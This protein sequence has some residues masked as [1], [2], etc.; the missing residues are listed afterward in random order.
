MTSTGTLLNDWYAAPARDLPWR[1][2]GTTPW[3]VLLS[4]VMSQQTPVARVI[5]R[6][7]RWLELWPRPADLAA[8]P[9]ADVLR[10]WGS[11]GYPRRALRLRECAQ[12][13][14]DALPDTVAGLEALP[15][16]GTYTARAVAAF[17]F[18]RAVPVVDTNVRRVHHRL[19]RGVRLPG[20][21]RATDLVDVADLMPWV[22]E[23]PALTRRGYTNPTHDPA[24]RD[25]ALGMCASLMELGATV[26]VART[27]RCDRCPVLD[28]CRW[29]ALGRPEPTE[30]ERADA[31]RRVQTFEGTDR[32]ARGRIMALLRSRETADAAALAGVWGDAGQRDRA[33]RSLMDDGL[34]TRTGDVW[35]L[36][37]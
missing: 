33:V 15:G 3:A 14:G 9:T 1:R 8:A 16:I 4:E 23:D 27:P 7:E 19:V 10:E 31:R 28:R 24:R 18:G 34:V 32:Q 29:T 20:P 6:W 30:R 37:R 11:L 13:V 26:C 2:P 5:P 21:A 35:H 12:A 36:P 22:D 17:A 25:E